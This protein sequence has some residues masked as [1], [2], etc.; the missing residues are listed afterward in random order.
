MSPR[1]VLHLGSSLTLHLATVFAVPL[2]EV[3]Q[4][5]RSQIPTFVEKA[6]TAIE[7]RGESTSSPVHPCAILIRRLGLHEVGIYRIS[8]E[9]R[10]IQETK[11]ALNRGVDPTKL[12]ADMDVHNLTGLVKLFLRDVS[13]RP[14][15]L[16][17]DPDSSPVRCRNLSSLPTCTT[18]SS[19]PMPSPTT[20]SVSTPSVT[21]SGR[22]LSPTSSSAVDSVS[23]STSKSTSSSSLSESR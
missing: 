14:T 15:S 8:G 19:K 11:A 6:L 3:L 7:Q 22:C 4:R 1:P 21:S 16:E 12:V 17:T 5:E 18:P 23:I 20:I 13:S 9:N 2:W 10:V